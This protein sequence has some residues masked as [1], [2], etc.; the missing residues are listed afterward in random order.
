MSRL[1]IRVLPGYTSKG[2]E[3]DVHSLVRRDG[4]AVQDALHFTFSP[5][6]IV[7]ISWKL[8]NIDSVIGGCAAAGDSGKCA[9][10]FLSNIVA[11][12]GEQI[13]GL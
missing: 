10:G 1:N 11:H 5:G 6:A 9:P 7:R 2:L 8:L 4:A 12:G 13:D 3:E